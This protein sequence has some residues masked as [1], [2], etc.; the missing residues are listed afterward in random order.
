MALSPKHR[1][2]IGFNATGDLGPFT[3]YTS[4][5]QGTVWFLRPLTEDKWCFRRK[6]YQNRFTFAAQAWR[7]LTPEKRNAW[8]QACRRAHLYL[9]GYALWVSWQVK[10]DRP[11]IRT[12]ERQSGVQLL[13]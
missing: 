12:I 3:I 1:Y 9:C 5:K 13:P 8:N 7:L 10:R 11:T 4:R 2:L 6:H